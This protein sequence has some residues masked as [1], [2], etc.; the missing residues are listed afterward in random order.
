GVVLR[1]DQ[2]RAHPIQ[3]RQNEGIHYLVGAPSETVPTRGIFGYRLIGA[4]QPTLSGG[5]VAPGTFTGNAAVQFGPGEAPRIGIDGLVTF[6][7]GTARLGTLGFS[8]QG[9][10]ENP[11]QSTLL[12]GQ[13]FGFTDHVL[14]VRQN[15]ADPA[16]CGSAG[17]SV[18]LNGG[19]FGTNAA[20]LGFTYSIGSPR[21][22]SPTVN[23]A[24]VF[25]NPVVRP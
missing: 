12:A 18:R 21:N 8:T 22:N 23:G 20:Q 1:I 25:G 10:A 24:A 4:T 15:G 2:N 6:G 14:T 13:R 7:A 9:G 19:L 16:G 3:L 17:C 11:D 5:A